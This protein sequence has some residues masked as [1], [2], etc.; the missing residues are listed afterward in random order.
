MVGVRYILPYIRRHK[1][2]LLLSILCFVVANFAA[3]LSPYVLGRGIDAVTR[4]APMGTLALIGVFLLLATLLEGVFRFGARYLGTGNARDIEYELRNDLFRAYQRQD[5]SFFQTFRTGDLMARATNDLNA[6]Q[7]SL[8]AGFS[9]LANTVIALITTV[10]A[11]LSIDV[12]LAILSILILPFTSVKMASAGRAIQRRFE[13][14]QER[15]ADISTKVQENASGIRVVKAYA[16]EDLEAEDFAHVN[17]NY[18]DASIAQLRIQSLLWPAMYVVG[19][20]ATVVVLYVGGMDV[21][22]GHITVGQLVQFLAYVAALRWPMVSLGWVVNLVQQGTAS[23]IRLQRILTRA[24]AIQ[25]SPDA[26]R[27]VR[28]RGEVEFRHVS[29]SY[30]GAEVL[31]DI[32]FHIP[33]GAT[34]ALVGPTGSGKSSIASLI[35]RIWDPTSGQ[36]L[37]DGIDVRLIP[38]AVLRRSVGYVPQETFLFSERIRDNIAYGVGDVPDERIEWAARISQLERDVEQFPHGYDTYLGERGVTLSGGQKQRTGIA[39]AIIKDPSILILDDALSSVDTYTEDQILEGLRG[40]METRTSLIIAHR[41]S[42]VQHADHILVIDDGRIMEQGTHEELVR[43]GGMYASMYRRQL[44]AE[45]MSVADLEED[46]EVGTS[47][48]GD[49]RAE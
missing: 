34:Y 18:M 30:D 48:D 20:A 16:Q 28:L 43:L 39:R 33:A 42:T 36:V 3:L 29:L 13:K 17:Q 25:D 37:I 4:H 40:V 1:A 15:F 8:G 46:V 38:L 12:K 2:K 32:N 45:E 31:H 22:S 26:V 23:M 11:M 6:V 14:V 41:I 49:Q 47:G 44:L 24:P 9:N 10:L 19:G 7:R 27:V 21:I 5:A 35:P